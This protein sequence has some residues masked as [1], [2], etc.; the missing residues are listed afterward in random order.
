MTKYRKESIGFFSVVL[1]EPTVSLC[2]A[3]NK[4]LH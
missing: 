4:N 2:V 1:C 3:K